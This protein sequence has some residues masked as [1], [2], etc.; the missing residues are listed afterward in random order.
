MSQGQELESLVKT[1]ECD[2]KAQGLHRDT[3]RRGL[4]IPDGR[5]SLEGPSQNMA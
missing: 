5:K 4:A 1:P 3:V 2:Y